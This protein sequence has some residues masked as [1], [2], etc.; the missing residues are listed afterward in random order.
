[1]W[2]KVNAFLPKLKMETRFWLWADSKEK[3]N[4]MIEEK[5]ITNIQSIDEEPQP[6]W[7]WKEGKK[8]TI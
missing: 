6:Y 2:Y 4:K 3:L 5:N 7:E 8:I 1:M